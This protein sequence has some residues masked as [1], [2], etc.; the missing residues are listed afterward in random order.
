MQDS[1]CR[2]LEFSGPMFYTDWMWWPFLY[3]LLLYYSPPVPPPPHVPP[4]SSSSCL[5]SY[6]CSSS[7]LL[8]FLR[9]PAPQTWTIQWSGFIRVL[10]RWR[11][12]STSRGL[13]SCAV[14]LTVT[15][16]SVTPGGGAGKRWARALTLVWRSM[17]HS[18]H[19]WANTPT[20]SRTG[21]C[22]W[23]PCRTGL[24]WF[25]DLVP[26][27]WSI[28]SCAKFFW[29]VLTFHQ[30][31]THVHFMV[32]FI[33]IIMKHFL[34]RSHLDTSLHHD[35]SQVLTNRKPDQSVLLFYLTSQ[36]HHHRETSC[37][38]TYRQVIN[39]HYYCTC[40]YMMYCSTSVVLTSVLFGLAG[41]QVVSS[42]QKP[43]LL[44]WLLLFGIMFIRLSSAVFSLFNLTVMRQQNGKADRKLFHLCVIPAGTFRFSISRV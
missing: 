2:V 16:L 14:L 13:C 25:L 33:L 31:P 10:V 15:H 22:F 36:W 35:R 44:Y 38:I 8:P 12:S 20:T 18:S 3:L 41:W 17:N 11:S 9:C 23:T 29:S 39:R 27:R 5:S 30:K 26:L 37:L 40:K 43:C 24:S 7:V 6:S 28:V 32:V 1:S 19:R 4:L 21:T 42:N 34:I